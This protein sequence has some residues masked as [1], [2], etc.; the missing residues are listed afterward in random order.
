MVH[1]ELKRLRKENNFTLKELSYKV[2]YGTGNLSSYENGRL[3]PKDPTVLRMLTRGYD[4]SQKEAKNE[5]AL[6]RQ[7]EV[8]EIYSNQL[9][10]KPNGYN[11]EPRP[12]NIAQMLAEEGLAKA[13]IRKI[14]TTIKAC[15]KRLR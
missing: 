4:L 13:D 5:L 15:K 10:Q 2:G 12:K 14:I 7:M 3:A 9:S 1:D 6:W 8:Q 11:K